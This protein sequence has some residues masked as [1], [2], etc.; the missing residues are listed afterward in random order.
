VGLEGAGV[1]TKA[2]DASTERP[3]GARR[4]ASLPSRDGSIELPSLVITKARAMRGL[5]NDARGFLGDLVGSGRS[6]LC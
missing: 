3:K 2:G 5:S 1:S 4:T 6:Q